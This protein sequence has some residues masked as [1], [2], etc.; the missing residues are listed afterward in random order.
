MYSFVVTNFKFYS[1]KN[2]LHLL[3][4]LLVMFFVQQSFA[5]QRIIITGAV[6]EHSG[7][8]PG[9]TVI[10]KGTTKGTQTD[11]DG[12]YTIEANIGDTLVF[13]YI[14]MLSQEIVVTAESKKIDVVLQ[15]G[16][17]LDDVVVVGYSS[18]EKK[19]LTSA[20][21]TVSGDQIARVPVSTF[22]NA[23]QGTTSGLLVESGSGQ[24]GAT[25]SLTIRGLKSVFLSSQPLYIF[26]GQQISSTDFAAINPSDI[27]S[28]SVLKDAA[29]T[30]IYGSRGANGVIV[31]TSK[32][33]KQGK[34]KIEYHTL[35]GISIA[36]S[37]N[38][39][40]QPLSS[41]QLIDL[42]QEIGI[43]ATLGLP[44]SRIDELRNINENWLDVLTRDGTTQSHELSASGGNENT[45]FYL[46]GSYFSQEGIALR[47]K[48]N[49]YSLRSKIDYNK[50]NL[51]IGANVFL[52][53]TEID[54][55]ES[56]GRFSRS[57]P[58][59]SSIRIPAYD[60][61]I[62]PVTGTYA[63]PLDPTASS[64]RNLLERIQTNDEKESI[65]KAI[66]SINGKYDFKFLEG[67]SFA[68]RWSLDYAHDKTRDYID[69]TSIA[70]LTRQGGSGELTRGFGDRSAFTGTNS[71]HYKFT[72]KDEHQFNVGVYQE[73]FVKNND[74]VE[75]SV[76]GLN[77][78]TTIAGATQGSEDN[79]FIPNFSG[80]TQKTTL[81]SYFGTLDYSYQN[82]YNLTAGFRR[83][84][85]SRFGANN[86]FGNF[87]SVGFGWVLTEE[88]FL[89]S[90]KV[91]NYLKFRASYGT[92]GN[93]RIDPIAA[94]QVFVGTSYNGASGIYGELS[95]PDLKWEE[96]AK[97]NLGIDMRFLNNKISLNLDVYHEKTTNLFQKVP[98][99]GTTGFSSQLRNVGSLK[100]EGI[101][102]NISTVNIETENFKWETGFNI[103]AN[104]TTILKLNNG[105]SFRT[106]RFLVEEGGKFP[107]FN[108]VRRAG[109]N[110]ANGR[111]LW[112]DL[113]GNLTEEYN[114]NNAVNVGR[115]TPRYYGGFYNNITFGRFNLRTNF[116]YSQG[117][118]IYNVARTSLDNPTKISRGSVS[119][120]ALRFWRQPG[121]ITD[122]PDP[123]QISNYFT[124]S[125]WLEDASYIKLRNVVFS[126][127]LS[128]N[129]LKKIN[130]SGFRI[131]IQGQ[132]LYTW[133]SFSGL[134]PENSNYN[135]VA[136]YPSLSTY[137]VGIDVKL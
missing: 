85:S 25:S 136:D 104:E 65:S 73:Y 2:Q 14:G 47:S 89:S 88:N 18:K 122:I 8:L 105:E 56:E 42:Q 26:D 126:Y 84:G 13:S 90:S 70:G 69:P 92:V 58:F 91:I 46:S 16:N 41:S 128:K 83:D 38:D 52:S 10:I 100:N 28:V 76:F 4:A 134:D 27:E 1:M 62:D 44:Q 81:T 30:Q 87:Y 82:R 33:G 37:Y 29:A 31:I 133:T 59:Y 121:D 43:G 63:E 24:P 77:Q 101:E 36:P 99:S 9:A 120:N 107:V 86:R 49:R 53:Y 93:Q 17:L 80:E 117:K 114:A 102:F 61:A 22:D 71:L 60:R 48:L 97:T 124:D 39:G 21:T 119:T 55:S 45:K 129:A 78:L 7:P 79:G 19:K 118:K 137:T 66:V 23:L 6:S 32:S 116:T 112:Y 3:V 131:Y 75:L 96:T 127:N 64:T 132:N 72:V 40:L 103:A 113:D 125:G 95:N 130:L 67:L 74:L 51:T 20:I 15:E 94:R 54:D 98:L 110:P 135:Y 34:T 115:A 35:Y 12:K 68:T 50:D 108:L 123:R 11:F 57:N 106:G 5:Q 109:V 111:L